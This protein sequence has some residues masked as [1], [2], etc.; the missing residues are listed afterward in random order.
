[1]RYP[2]W[3]K[4]RLP[5]DKNFSS[6]KNLLRTYSVNTVCVQAGC[7]NIFECF[8]RKNLTFL[9]LGNIC[10]RNCAYCRVEKGPAPP[11]DENEPGRIAGL[12]KELKLAYVVI[13]SVTRDDLID[14]G[15]NQFAKTIRAISSV[16]PETRIEVLT[17]DFQGNEAGLENVLSAKPFIFAHNLEVI[18]ELFPALRPRASYKG[19][20]NLLAR[21][22]KYG[23][24]TKSGI[25]TGLGESKRQLSRAFSHLREAGVDI[26]TIGQYLPPS[27]NAA[28]VKK[29]YSPGEF[30][31]LKEKAY[32][33]GFRVVFAGPFV[34]SSYHAEELARGIKSPL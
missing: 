17:P 19:S 27:K 3:L 16:S 4:I 33:M 34:R 8:S 22:K 6:M 12:V 32:N 2:D 1:M 25:M 7:P 21:A 18:K 13:T 14:R 29:F 9:I 10:T 26:L 31:E 24:I 5:A 20:L 28:R 30:E 23:A 11:V 15:S